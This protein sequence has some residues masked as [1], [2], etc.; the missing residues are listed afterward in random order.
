M[1]TV[2]THYWTTTHDTQNRT[3][4]HHFEHGF[5]VLVDWKNTQIIASKNDKIIA[6][7]N[8]EVEKITL[9]EYEDILLTIEKSVEQLNEFKNGKND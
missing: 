1:G 5:K 2:K 6:K 9:T 4:T 7:T 3:M 8:M